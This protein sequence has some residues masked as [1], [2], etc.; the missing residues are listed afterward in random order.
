[1]EKIEIQESYEDYL[2]AIYHIAKCN[3]GGW[4]SNSEIANLL[5]VRPSSVSSMLHKLKKKGLIYWK[6]RKS[7]RLSKEGKKIAQN[8][9]KRYN[10]LKDFFFNILDIKDERLIKDLSCQIEHH[11]TPEVS[12]ALQDLN[13][14]MST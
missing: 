7:L 11:I 12:E 2:K 10:L 3:R 13:L 14:K 1:M 4:V 5:N 8:M 9:I 6:P